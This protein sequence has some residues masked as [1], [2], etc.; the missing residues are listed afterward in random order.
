MTGRTGFRVRSALRA[1]GVAAALVTAVWAPA[2]A[3]RVVFDDMRVL[4][5]D[6]VECDGPTCRLYTGGGMTVTAANRIREIRE[7]LVR[8]HAMPHDPMWKTLAGPF[9][10]HVERAASRHGVDPALLVAVIRAE[11]AFDPEAVSPKGAIGL[12]QLMPA[13]AELLAVDDPTDPGQNIDGGARWLRR[14]L[15]RFEGDLE[16]ALAAYNAGP[17]TVVRYG[18]VPPYRETRQYVR[19]V[20]RHLET[21]TTDAGDDA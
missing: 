3:D 15:D 6:R 1:A 7:D 11:S 19:A 17:E 16:L 5:V 18:G 20:Q 4:E 12:M 2:R 13:T 10:S 9:L 8:E 14:M 21:L